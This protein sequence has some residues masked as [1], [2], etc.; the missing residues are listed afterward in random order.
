MREIGVRVA[1]GASARGVIT[2]IFRRPLTQVVLGIVA[3]GSSAP[4]P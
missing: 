3:G 2:S 4:L 1:L